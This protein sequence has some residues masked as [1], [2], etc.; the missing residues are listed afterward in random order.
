MR[1]QEWKAPCRGSGE[2]AETYVNAF[3]LGSVPQS[4]ADPQAGKWLAMALYNSGARS[5]SAT[6]TDFA[7]H[8]EWT[9]A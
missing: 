1:L 5:L 2:G 4:V 3:A 6:Q 7:Q 9:A 8:P